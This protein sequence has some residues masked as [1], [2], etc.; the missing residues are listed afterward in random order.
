MAEKTLTVD[1][2]VDRGSK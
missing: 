2:P 1:R